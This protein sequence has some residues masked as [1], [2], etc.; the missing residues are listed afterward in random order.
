MVGKKQGGHAPGGEGVFSQA[1][2]SFLFLF[3]EGARV[4]T[5]T[6]H[7]ALHVFKEF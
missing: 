5:S 1:L 3:G 2:P 4:G 6:D 7:Q